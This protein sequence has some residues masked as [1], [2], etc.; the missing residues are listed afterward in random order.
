MARVQESRM[1]ASANRSARPERCD[2]IIGVP[3]PSRP[4][5][6]LVKLPPRVELIDTLSPEVGPLWAELRERACSLGLQGAYF[7]VV[8]S[9]EH[10]GARV[11]AAASAR[12]RPLLD[13]FS[14]GGSPEVDVAIRSG[15]H[16]SEPDVWRPEVLMAD[17]PADLRRAR[18]AW[19]ER[20]ASDWGVCL[21]HGFD[22]PVFA[23]GGWRGLFK[24]NAPEGPIT[25]AFMLAVQEATERFHRAYVQTRRRA[26]ARQLTELE[27]DAL[28]LVGD[29][30]S[31]KMAVGA[32]GV[33]PKAVEKAL[34]RARI[35]LDAGNTAQAVLTAYQLGMIA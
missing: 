23:P 16:A 21:H 30:H 7:L 22:V 34:E 10:G 28:R 19:I 13:A 18:L 1:R 31:C 24:I 25:P 14:A 11:A 3:P 29:G 5:L 15:F 27:A 4:R 32:L 12:I 20:A 2:N 17:L 8:P 26:K 9:F 35:K 33:S 6:Q